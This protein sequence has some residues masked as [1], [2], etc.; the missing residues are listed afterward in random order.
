M[1]FCTNSY[2]LPCLVNMFK[3]LIIFKAQMMEKRGGKHIGI[4]RI[5]LDAPCCQTF[6]RKTLA[7]RVLSCE[8][9]KA[10]DF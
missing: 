6:L 3:D 8:S 1:L 2:C 4:T 9:K 7:S 10:V 5:E